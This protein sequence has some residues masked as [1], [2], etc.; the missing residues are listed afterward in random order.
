MP[1]SV[2]R[3]QERAAIVDEIVE[4]A[5]DVL[6]QNVEGL[7]PK[8]PRPPL[9]MD[10]GW[11]THNCAIS[12]ISQEQLLWEQRARLAKSGIVGRV[13]EAHRYRWLFFN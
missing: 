9:L 10:Q 11:E 13:G 1:R 4:L 3:P 8:V 12:A 2:G 6:T 5:T 7:E